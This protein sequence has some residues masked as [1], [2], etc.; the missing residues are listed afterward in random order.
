M[1]ALQLATAP[2]DQSNRI[3][4]M[5]ATFALKTIHAVSRVLN[6]FYPHFVVSTT[7]KNIM[8]VFVQNYNRFTTKS[9]FFRKVAN[10]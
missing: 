4:Q 7:K 8:C 5:S 10:T 9:C 3:F 1:E 6:A 2:S